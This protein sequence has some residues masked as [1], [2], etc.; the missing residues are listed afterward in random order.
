[1]SG[2]YQHEICKTAE[3]SW[4]FQECAL[5]GGIRAEAESSLPIPDLKKG[6]GVTTI[7]NR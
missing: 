7:E 2:R 6:S 4:F 3:E 5:H 1:M